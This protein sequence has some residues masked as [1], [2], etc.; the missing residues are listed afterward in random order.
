MPPGR[1]TAT[2]RNR[3]T[4]SELANV[5]IADTAMRSLATNN[6]GRFPGRK[7][8]NIARAT[9]GSG[10]QFGTG[11]RLVAKCGQVVAYRG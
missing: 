1:G 4:R 3:Q 10:G 2:R 8:L 11:D 7:P 5:N 6:C 9:I